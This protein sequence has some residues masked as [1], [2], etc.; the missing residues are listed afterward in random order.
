MIKLPTE[1]ELTRAIAA[2]LNRNYLPLKDLGNEIP[3]L[4]EMAGLNL[5]IDLYDKMG[6]E[7]VPANLQNGEYHYKLQ[8]NGLKYNFSWF[9]VS[10]SY[11]GKVQEYEIHEN[12]AVQ[13]AG[14]EDCFLHPDVAVVKKDT[15]EKLPNSG[16]LVHQK[17]Y[18]YVKNKN[19]KTFLE[20]KYLRPFPEL[21]LNFPG[22]LMALRP[23]NKN[24]S[25]IKRGPK[26]VA[27]IFMLAGT[28]NGHSGRISKFL[29]EKYHVNLVFGSMK[30]SKT[31]MKGVKKITLS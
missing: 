10:R 3:A 13:V 20:A 12:L 14:T 19:L 27:P 17:E 5:V 18:W 28:A 1:Q 11:Y 29:T 16:I 26:H 31:K 30:I 8:P 22:M 15:A 9:D 25:R 4:F 24:Y 21:L 23:N 2:F 6:Y 7:T